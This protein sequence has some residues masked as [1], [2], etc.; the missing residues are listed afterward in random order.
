MSAA[1]CVSVIRCTVSVMRDLVAPFRSLHHTRAAQPESE[2]GASVDGDHVSG[3]GRGREA[4]T[5]AALGHLDA[6]VDCAT[7]GSLRQLNAAIAGGQR[8]DLR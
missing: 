4:Q 7:D 8:P 1:S 3:A 5:L 6:R 2:N